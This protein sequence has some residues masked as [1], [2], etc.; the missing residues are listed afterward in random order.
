M[1]SVAVAT[2]GGPFGLDI[3]AV[4][5]P[6]TSDVL[7]LPALSGFATEAP[8]SNRIVVSREVPS[9][10]LAVSV[11]VIT[12]AIAVPGASRSGRGVTLVRPSDE[13][14]AD[15]RNETAD[16]EGDERVRS[17]VAAVVPLDRTVADTYPGDRCAGRLD[18]DRLVNDAVDVRAGSICPPTESE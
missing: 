17:P 18:P 1:R 3:G 5:G 7:S 15:G 16:H 8:G 2:L 12:F 13:Q 11:L 10:G 14:Y 6:A 4:V 9:Y